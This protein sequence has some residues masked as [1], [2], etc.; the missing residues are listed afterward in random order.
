MLIR[1][2][3]TRYR[4]I[5]GVLRIC[6][7]LAVLLFIGA[8]ARL[9]AANH[10]EGGWD[11]ASNLIAA[12]SVATGD[13][14][15]TIQVQDL[16]DPHP[17]PGRETVRAPGVVY[18][19]AGV[20]RITHTWMKA[21]VWFNLVTILIAVFCLRGAV[22]LV[23]PAWSADIAGLLL[24]ANAANY[25]LVPLVNNNALTA[26]TCIALLI[27]ALARRRRLQGMRLAVACGAVGAAAFLVKQSYILG[28]AAFATILLASE[29]RYSWTR[30]ALHIVLA[31][32]L[33]ALFS[34]PYW[35]PN[36]REHGTPLYSPIQELRL[37]FRYG[38]IPTETYQR[39]VYLG[40]T[41]PGYH[42]IA[43]MIGTRS[44]LRRE[45]DIVRM[46]PGALFGRGALVLVWAI[47]MLVF[48][49]RRRW[50]LVLAA[51][52][53]AIPPFFDAI[54]WVPEARYFF[55]VYPIAIFIGA[56]AV[57]DYR[58]VER[59]EFRPAARVRFRRA[60][61]LLCALVAI[62]TLLQT[63]WGW[64]SEF[65]MARTPE[66]AWIPA[67]DGLPAD[68]VVLTTVPPQVSWWTSRPTV[69]EPEG[70]RADLVEVLRLYRPGFYLDLSPGARS[71]RPPFAPNE[72]EP[73]GSGAGWALYR[74]HG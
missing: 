42:A 12:R 46:V 15:T 1:D 33:M 13:G 24:L 56:L 44:M 51:L 57:T 59:R 7:W 74:L 67:V 23:A 21:M 47:A 17:I 9:A 35:L 25:Q 55:P 65:A 48:M 28:F 4:S 16:V 63:R 50:V 68:A 11:S 32:T 70:T 54:W 49:R 36:L 45:L 31:G 22:G 26:V 71:N 52:A 18:L 66:P 41:V 73:I 14:F 69:V 29:V 6:F 30:R 20:L 38:V 43:Q 2:A 8:G 34:I 40:K 61:T 27:V 64:R 58:W 53:L 62:G 60:F 72:L 19:F 37:P 5:P 10:S 3:V 39:V